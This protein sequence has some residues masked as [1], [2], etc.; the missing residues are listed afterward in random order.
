MTGL[1]GRRWWL[2]SALVFVGSLV[3]LAPTTADFG[4]TWDEPAYRY[5]QEISQHWW[6]RCAQAR[7][8]S[9]LG[10]IFSAEALLYYW[11][12]G[13]FGI[14]F[15]PPFAGQLN[16]LTYRAFGSYLRDI[17]ARRMASVIEFAIT[18]TI[19]FGFLARRYGFGVGFVAAGSLLLMPRLYGQ[20]HLIDTDTPGLMLWAAT[21][22][23]FWKGLHETNARGWRVLVGVLVGLAFVEKMGA[24]IVLLPLLV[25]L[26][27]SRVSN[28]F[29]PGDRRAAW[30]DGI[31]TSSLM[32][33][34]LIVAFLEIRR[35]AQA[36]LDIQARKG[37]P[38]HLIGPVAT[39]MFQDHPATY[40]PAAILAIPLLV[41]VIRR[42]LGWIS[43]KSSV[44]SRERPALEIW[45]AILAFAPLVSWLGNPA[46][47][48]ET[49]PRLAHYYSINSQR[50]GVLPDIQIVY[51]GQ[52]YEYSLP[53]HNAWVLIAMT[54][55][56]LILAA[57]AVGLIYGLTAVK[58]DRIPLYF[59]VH[60]LTLPVMRMLPT[61]AHDGVRLFLP[62]FF[63][64]A[65]FAGWGVM[66]SG[67]LLARFLAIKAVWPRILF[68][69]AVLGSA[70]WQL[71]KIHPY[72]LSYYNEW[73]GGPKGAWKAGFE[74]SYWYDALNPSVLK[75][76]NAR[77][78]QNAAV[79]F[80]NEMSKPVMV[81]QDLQSLGELRGDLS[82]GARSLDK[83][84]F[85]WLLTH[86]SK[87]DGFSRLLF[88]MRP[89]YESRPSQLSGLRVFTVADPE[90]TSRAW[91]LQ[92]L[93]DGT[94]TLPPDPPAAPE[95]IQNNL[96]PL[97]RL[98][99][100]GITRAHH[101]VINEPIFEWAMRDP[102]GLRAAAQSL[103]DWHP[104]ANLNQMLVELSE[105]SGSEK[106]LLSFDP[107]KP[108]SNQQLH[109][110][111]ILLRARPKALVEAVE[112]LI[113][114][115]D[116]VRGVLTRYPYTDPA[117]LGGYLDRKLPPE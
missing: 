28:A 33:I 52:T 26:G 109:R 55:P 35:L 49:L 67:D 93:L 86:D 2:A 11:P 115:P 65:A 57:S 37:V 25:W 103:S 4:L 90:A 75:E 46:W 83:F 58:K 105:R 78:P 21:A 54:V 101:L 51:W 81:V 34:P 116:A 24:V 107:K 63:F 66:A 31:V 56:V 85:I 76:L 112:I 74:L 17:P 9:D 91:A 92:I 72:E 71:I 88:G 89:W 100:D 73:I 53:W 94:D 30:I 36:Y 38:R 106:A 12:Y 87:A 98:W 77:F 84:P 69:A 14:N 16:L 18:L 70:G 95:W 62:S 79:E 97:A 114:Q 48:R 44:W 108:P 27:T 29:R 23:A 113:D 42:V 15:H 104:S 6:A 96:A 64:L 10:K 68:G 45:T 110:L 82:L 3:A 102:A 117:G 7:S 13:R 41:W 8:R 43:P 47:W 20:A 59:L 1:C 40:L 5:S 99:G 19:L 22:I 39:N 61:P 50:R 60:L 111:R 32:L 80:A